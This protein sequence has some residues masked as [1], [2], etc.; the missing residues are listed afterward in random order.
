MWILIRIDLVVLDPDPYRECGSGSMSMEID[1]NL[2]INL[3]SC[4]SKRPVNLRMYVL[5]P[6]SYIK[7]IFHVKIQLFVTLK[8]DQDPDPH[9]S[10]LVWLP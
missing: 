9:G 3:V 1:Q 8:S 4:F 7:F 6:I 10:A 5:L 2:Q